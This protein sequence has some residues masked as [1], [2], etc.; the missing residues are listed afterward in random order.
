MATD[1]KQTKIGDLE[2]G[3][4]KEFLSECGFQ[5]VEKPKETEPKKYV[6]GLRGIQELFHVSHATAQAYKNTFLRD[7]C[8][9]RGR[10]IIIDV[11]Q[12]LQLFKNQK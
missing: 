12:A 3:Q 2:A 1:I 6:Y 11:E 7:A 4:L 9:Q 5:R 8:S 10:K